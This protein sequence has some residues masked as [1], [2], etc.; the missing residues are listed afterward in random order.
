[1]RALLI[2]A[3]LFFAGCRATGSTAQGFRF[4]LI[5]VDLY[6]TQRVGNAEAAGRLKETNIHGTIEAERWTTP[7]EECHAVR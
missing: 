4:Y 7:K 3:C 5:G 2:L 6:N 1:M